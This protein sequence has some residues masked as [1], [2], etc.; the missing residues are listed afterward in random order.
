MTIGNALSFIK[1]GQTDSALRKRLNAAGSPDE[2]SEILAAEKLNFSEHD[3]DEAY[4][5]QLTQCQE[6]EQA[7]QLREFKMWW[8]LLCQII[9][10]GACGG[11]C[12]TCG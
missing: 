5:H 9:N 2:L 6:E 4:H 10:P 7:D 1:R 11:M 12:G 3:F 8:D